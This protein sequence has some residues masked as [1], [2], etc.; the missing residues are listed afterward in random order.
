M[1]EI[2]A[3]GL[4]YWRQ[5]ILYKLDLMCPGNTYVSDLKFATHPLRSIDNIAPLHNAINA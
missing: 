4:S 2:Y 3:E 5:I 1:L